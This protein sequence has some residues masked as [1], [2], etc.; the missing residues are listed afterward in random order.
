MCLLQ[1]AQLQSNV[2][3]LQN[4]TVDKQLIVRLES[5][6]RDLENRL[7]LETT[8]RHRAD[9]QVTRLKEQAE[10]IQTEKVRLSDAELKNQELQ[11]RLQRQLRDVQEEL[12]DLQRKEGEASQRKHD[13]VCVVMHRWSSSSCITNTYTLK[14]LGRTGARSPILKFS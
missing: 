2:E 8:S 4:N 3:Y 13:L 14:E 1:L 7:E 5:K 11:K 9:Q 12:A 6:I 10:E